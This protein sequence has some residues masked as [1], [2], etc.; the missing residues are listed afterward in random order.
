MATLHWLWQSTPSAHRRD[1]AAPMDPPFIDP[2]YRLARAF[3]PETGSTDFPIVGAAYNPPGPVDFDGAI[4]IVT[5]D[6]VVG[7]PG[8]RVL[9]L[10]LDTFGAPNS[11]VLIGESDPVAGQGL[12]AHV[13]VY[14]GGVSDLA[15]PFMDVADVGLS[16]MDVAAGQYYGSVEIRAT[17]AASGDLVAPRAGIIRAVTLRDTVGIFPNASV[18]V[19]TTINGADI[20]IVAQVLPAGVAVNYP[21]GRLFAFGDVLRFGLRNRD[22]GGLAI[23]LSGFN[24]SV[25]IEWS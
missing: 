15:V 8:F 24:I 11:M 3:N 10:P 2:P 23:A 22:P 7:A 25:V 19:V 6:G 1:V 21:V 13:E 18:E 14:P 5:A 17:I 12:G 9:E 20:F 16:S 4:D